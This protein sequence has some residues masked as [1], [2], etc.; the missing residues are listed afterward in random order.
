MPVI[1]F[2]INL[3]NKLVGQKLPRTV[4]IN[5][6]TELGCDIE[7]FSTIAGFKC[8][9]CGNVWDALPDSLPEKCPEC[10]GDSFEKIWEEEIIR[11]EIQPS[12]PDMMDEYGLSRAIKGWLGIEKGLKQ[13]EAKNSDYKLFVDES[14]KDI[15]PYIVC[16]V[17]KGLAFDDKDIRILMKLQ[18]YLHWAVGRDR[19]RASIGVYD[20]DKIKFPVYYKAIPKSQIKFKPLFM[21]DEIEFLKMVEIHPKCKKFYH[22]IKDFDRSPVLVDAEGKILSTPPLINS[23][24]T[25]VDFNTKN[26][27]IDVT[28]LNPYDV[29]NALNILCCSLA[30]RGAQIFT[31]DVNY[32][33]NTAITPDFSPKEM[34]VN[35]E[36][37]KKLIGMDLSDKEIE[38]SLL[39]MRFGIKKDVIQI[40]AYR[41]DILSEVDIVEDVAIGYA[42]SK[43]EKKQLKTFTIGEPDEIEEYTNKVREI[44]IGLGFTEVMTSMLTNPEVHFK[45]MRKE[46]KDETIFI[47]NPVS[48]EYTIVRTELIQQ[49]LSIFQQNVQN[50]MPQKIFEV[51]DICTKNKEERHLCAGIMSAKANF[52]E[53]KSIAEAFFKSLGI[54][55]DYEPGA[56]PSFIKGR[57]AYIMKNGEKIGVMGELH[58]EV[59]E[60]FEL[61]CPVAYFEVKIL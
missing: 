48:E 6:L 12:R 8:N 3:L 21:R 20:L 40:P 57:C 22:L 1:G 30:E 31:V 17:A 16:A 2:H 39:K 43:I 35:Y 38:E 45:R 53:I 51:G 50:P 33:E 47:E 61:P 23:E 28:G 25:K 24:D 59:L 52:S 27:F 5:V 18:E 14:V 34:K 4:L 41:V 58:P 15:R 10:G 46:V 49:L 29:Q 11:A 56:E 37:I 36:F 60:N 9:V 19:K 54:K 7:G 32:P 13:Y 44:M 55:V 26:L 42:Y